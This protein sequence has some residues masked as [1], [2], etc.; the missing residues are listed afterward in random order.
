MGL[1]IYRRV[2][3]VLEVPADVLV[4]FLGRG[5]K[6]KRNRHT[7]A[8]ER[9][10]MAQRLGLKEEE[11]KDIDPALM[12]EADLDE[13]LGFTEEGGITLDLGKGLT[14]DKTG[15]AAVRLEKNK[16]LKFGD[17]NAI[18]V[19]LGNGLAFG[20]DGTIVID[21]G[22]GISFANGKLRVD[23]GSMLHF[24]E[25]GNITVKIGEGLKATEDGTMVVDPDWVKATVGY[26]TVP[27]IEHSQT[28]KLLIDSKLALDG[29]SL[30]LTKT[31][32]TYAI[33]RNVQGL[34][35]DIVFEDIT[36]EKD[37]VSIGSGY[38]YGYGMQPMNMTRSGSKD[39]PNF[40]SL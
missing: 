7:F 21:L 22:D 36:T 30:S 34:I 37:E 6:V 3:N 40:Y 1:V 38:G 23:L 9:D 35:L 5:L 31:Y 14:F 11:A 20:H 33:M 27:S 39:A 26:D 2:T 17:H 13:G 12:I 18:G 25:E 24:D 10:L 19:N 16:G 29:N 8:D 4:N 15:S 32:Q 28:V